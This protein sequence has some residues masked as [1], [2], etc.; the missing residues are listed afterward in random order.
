M[1]LFI[2]R[3]RHSCWSVPGPERG[4]RA[5][6][7]TLLALGVAEEISCDQRTRAASTPCMGASVWKYYV[8]YEADFGTA[9]ARLQE[10]VFERGEYYRRNKR[11]KPKT[12]DDLRKSNREDGTHS[13][14]D[15]THV[16]PKPTKPGYENLWTPPSA[17]AD[18]QI[19]MKR[20]D[21]DEHDRWLAQ[22][23]SVLG[24][25]RELHDDD[26]VALFGT[27]TPARASVEEHESDIQDLRERG[28]G[29]IVVIY[30]GSTPREL[31]FTGVSGD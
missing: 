13:I 24:S 10:Q 8:P 15:I 6:A 23:K 9:L 19:D 17:G 5:V 4:L 20:F 22:L 28:M 26:L 11:R 3:Q 27:T 7:I 21:A 29:T 16:G 12:I 30:D 25:V 18:G 1:L 14:L 2:V 31:L